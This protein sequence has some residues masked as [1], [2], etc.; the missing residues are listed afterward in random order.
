MTL[1]RSKLVD[2]AFGPSI[3]SPG[4]PWVEKAWNSKA[5][6]TR[7]KH[8]RKALTVDPDCIDAYVLL[9]HEAESDAEQ[10]AL[11]RE[12]VRVGDRLYAPI[13]DDPDMHWWGFIGTRPY[14]RAMQILGLA[15]EAIG[16]RAD[17]EAIYRR[18]L[19]MNPGDNQGIRMLLLR[20]LLDDGRVKDCAPIIA[21][22]EDDWSLEIMFTSL[23]IELD[24]NT[25]R[26]PKRILAEIAERNEHAV[27]LLLRTLKTGK[28]PADPSSSFVS[29]G[30][31]D[32]A[33]SY[34]ANFIECWQIKPKLVE[35]LKTLMAGTRAS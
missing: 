20:V 3:E 34:V 10:V 11:L 29:L 9:A 5:P 19:D 7:R 27:D 21:L 14:M 32:E 16:D 35:R 31:E 4:D 24:K 17:A 22:Y 23:M 15:H 12:A 6:A 26:A 28:A 18:L 25:K 33:L 13:L 1:R 30:S 8:A 2:D